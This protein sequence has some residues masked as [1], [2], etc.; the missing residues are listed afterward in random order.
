MG[1]WISGIGVGLSLTIDNERTHVVYYQ[2]SWL[3]GRDVQL[4]TETRDMADEAIRQQA[5]R[6]GILEQAETHGILYFENHLRALGFTD[7]Q[8]SV[9]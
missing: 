6:D 1:N 9:Q 7:V 4:E 8:I 2:K 3:V 5:L